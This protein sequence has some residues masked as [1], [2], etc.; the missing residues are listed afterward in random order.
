MKSPLEIRGDLPERVKFHRSDLPGLAEELEEIYNDR[1]LAGK[2][3]SDKFFQLIRW[4]QQEVQ[5]LQS[6]EYDPDFSCE[7]CGFGKQ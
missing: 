3:P 6:S 4:V 2:T 1:S 7:S 5:V